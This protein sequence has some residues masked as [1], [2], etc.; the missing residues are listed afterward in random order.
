MMEP[1]FPLWLKNS[2]CVYHLSLPTPLWAHTQDGSVS[3]L[4]CAGCIKH[5]HASVSVI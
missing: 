4:L 3:E 5:Q 1:C 2:Q